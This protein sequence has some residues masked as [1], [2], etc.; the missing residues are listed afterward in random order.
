MK[1]IALAFSASSLRSNFRAC[2]MEECKYKLW[3]MT[4]APTIPK[5]KN[6]MDLSVAIFVSGIKPRNTSPIFGSANATS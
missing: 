2:A 3:G 1:R 5:A 6:N 4:V